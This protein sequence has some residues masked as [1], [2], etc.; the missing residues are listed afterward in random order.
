[1]LSTVDTTLRPELERQCTV[2]LNKSQLELGSTRSFGD[3]NMGAYLNTT[4]PQNPT[5]FIATAQPTQTLAPAS[6]ATATAKAATVAEEIKS[7][8]PSQINLKYDWY[9]NMTHIFVAYKIKQ[10]GEVFANGGLSVTFTDCTMILENST[11]GE[12]LAC[13]EFSNKIDASCSTWTCTSKRID[14]K[15]KKLVDN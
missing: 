1:M 14:I 2:W 15:I 12:I 5:M 7:D 4:A 10:G 8:G 9:Q 6:T 13:V 3:I 11:T